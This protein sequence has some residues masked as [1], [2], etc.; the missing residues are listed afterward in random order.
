MRLTAPTSGRHARRGS[1]VVVVLWS[2]GIAAVLGTALQVFAFRA[3]NLGSSTVHEVQARWAAR[4]GVENAIAT[5][6]LHTQDPWPDDAFAI[7]RDLDRISFLDLGAATYEVVHHSARVDVNGPF[8]ESSKVNF[9]RQQPFVVYEL[10]E[11]ISPDQIA[12][13][14]DWTDADDEPS[15][16]GAEADYYLA[17]GLYQPRNAPFR[18]LPEL[19]LVAGIWP[20]F[21]RGEDTNLNHRRD[22]NEDDRTR[23]LPD[24]DGDGWLDGSW[25]RVITV[26]SLD[27]GATD[28]GQP[29]IHLKRADPLVLQDRLGVDELQADR[30]KAFGR[31]ETNELWQLIGLPLSTIGDDGT[32]GGAQPPA[33][34]SQPV[35][36]PLDDQQLRAVLAECTVRP[37]FDRRPGR[38]NINTAAPDLVRDICELA[39]FDESVADELLYVRNGTPEGFTSEVQ[40]A[41]L[42]AEVTPEDL[43]LLA[44]IFTVRSNVY[45]ISSVGRSSS[46]GTEVE[47]ICLVDRS[48]VPV[49]ILEYRER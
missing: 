47:I 33:D 1:V 49:R 12:G 31:G 9:N 6:A 7:V 8:D 43:Q 28:S 40:F 26:S 10:L 19:E 20:E 13:L 41:D 42:R 27:D 46:S 29:R 22:P 15:L 38:V 39:G 11:D 35:A 2:I 48:T 3:A 32:I 4:A 23:S 45:R 37:L 16:F 36:G 5:L 25:S 14:V 17:Q 44:S 21:V 30:L 24:D 18:S 34:P